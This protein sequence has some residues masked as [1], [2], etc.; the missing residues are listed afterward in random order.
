MSNKINRILKATENFE[1]F[2]LKKTAEP[3]TIATILTYVGYA[4]FASMVISAAA[5]Q[6]RRTKDL[7]ETAD[8]LI[9]NLTEYKEDYSDE[10]WFKPFSK[11]Y[12]DYLKHL[13]D[14]KSSGE[15]LTQAVE[16]QRADESLIITLERYLQ[17][18]SSIERLA[19]AVDGFLETNKSWGKVLDVAKSVGLGFGA[20]T[21]ATN[22]QE[23]LGA[24]YRYASYERSRYEDMLKK[25]QEKVK[26][27][28]NEKGIA[29]PGKS[30]KSNIEEAEISENISVEKSSKPKSSL[31][32]FADII[33]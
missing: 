31:E 10:D 15:I 18:L 12:D 32:D 25:I 7:M 11:N 5:T 2:V 28:R 26:A 23:A 22:A 27:E 1:S 6:I 29:S 20:E 19:P 14:L 13:E 4:F 17:T 8:K 30:S 3:I 9:K 16:A 21:D 33:S 24:F